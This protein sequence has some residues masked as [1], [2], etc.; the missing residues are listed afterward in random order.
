MRYLQKAKTL[1][2]TLVVGL[3][4]DRSVQLL[5]GESRP[6]I[7]DYQ[8]AEVIGALKPVDG[9]IIFAE[10]TAINL[11]QAI[12]PDI[13]VK[14]G[15]YQVDTLPEAATMQA[16]GGRIVLVQIEV[17]SSTSKIVAKIKQM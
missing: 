4:S 17:P 8:R 10:A 15:D 5:K 13:Y 1:G 2:K 12:A 16:L 9:V 14:G 7:P 3:N 6:I 11:I